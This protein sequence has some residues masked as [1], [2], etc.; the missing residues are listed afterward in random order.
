MK[1][2]E[3][4]RL[5][6]NSKTTLQYREG[7][8]T[9]QWTTGQWEQALLLFAKG[10]GI[11][12]ESRATHDSHQEFSEDSAHLY[13]WRV[14]SQIKIRVRIGSDVRKLGFCQFD[15]EYLKTKVGIL[16]IDIRTHQVRSRDREL[17]AADLNPDEEISPFP[18][19]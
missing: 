6:R 8:H 5:S 19:P 7:S 10:A 14:E 2:W 12:G 1:Q 17:Q 15:L 18:L 11:Q 16:G 4:Y 9:I 3:T 13:E